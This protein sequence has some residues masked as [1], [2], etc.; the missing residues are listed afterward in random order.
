M[1][2]FYDSLTYNQKLYT[3]YFIAKYESSWSWDGHNYEA[4]VNYGDPFTL[5]IM[6]WAGGNCYAWLSSMET[7]AA[8]VFG[9]LPSRWRD[10]V[11]NGSGDSLWGGYSMDWSDVET[12]RANAESNLDALKTFS[13]WYWIDSQNQESLYDELN[14]LP[15]AIG[16][17]YPDDPDLETIKKVYFYLA[18]FHN[19]GTNM[20][21]IYSNHGL[22]SD[23]ATIR[24]ATISMYEGFSNFGV[25]GQGW[26]N[27]INDNYN[28]L[29]EWD[30]ETVPDFGQLKGIGND[31]GQSAGST[32][33]PPEQES[34]W[35][36]DARYID[37][38]GDALC[39]HMADGTK[40]LFYKATNGVLWL[41][42][43]G[44]VQSGTTRPSDTAEPEPSDTPSIID[45]IRQWYVERENRWGYSLGENGDYD[46]SD[47]SGV[48]NCSACIRYCARQLAPNSEMAN[49]PYSYTGVMAE[50][51]TMIQ[52]GDSSTPFDYANCAPGDVLLVMWYD[53]NSDY[54]HVELFLGTE[55]QGNT[56][57]SE[58]WGAGS[59][60]CPH[61]N[62]SIGYYV[63][64]GSVCWWQLRRISWE[65]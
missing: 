26:V 22:S 21:Y 35:S 34:E 53:W 43:H 50:T 27:A 28:L 14:R 33:T 30:G 41:P 61:K 57:G 24:D 63:N 8:D 54:D 62:G 15:S 58:L 42:V 23:L 55:A 44:S 7:E 1:A 64:M 46:D 60:P 65:G 31:N 16:M 10:A 20:A 5:G 52:E 40:T 9:G 39:L 51:G 3:M 48:T 6:Q 13:Q 29:T 36:A 12:W 19:C 56:T 38:Y 32:S 4:N 45:Q 2:S 17:V 18:R 37:E 49:M 47:N 59:A 11:H 25:Y